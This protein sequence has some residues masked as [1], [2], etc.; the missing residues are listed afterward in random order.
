MAGASVIE[1]VA[2]IV[3]AAV[4]ETVAEMDESLYSFGLSSSNEQCII[5]FNHFSIIIIITIT[6]TITQKEW[7]KVDISC[8]VNEKNCLPWHKIHLGP[9][10]AHSDHHRQIDFWVGC[11]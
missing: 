2:K 4:I 11:V 5:F 6:I 3:G 10:L 8:F 7:E 1:T 9:S